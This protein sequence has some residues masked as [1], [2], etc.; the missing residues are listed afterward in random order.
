MYV[1]ICVCMYLPGQPQC[2]KKETIVGLPFSEGNDNSGHEG[3]FE[4][5]FG[6]GDILIGGGE[7]KE[8]NSCESVILFRVMRVAMYEIT[9]SRCFAEL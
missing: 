2:L 3:A 9:S 1:S 4:P 7:K 8:E 6:A 5:I